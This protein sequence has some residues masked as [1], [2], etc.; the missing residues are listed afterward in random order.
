MFPIFLSIDISLPI[1]YYLNQ[2]V[3]EIQKVLTTI[4]MFVTLSI[5]MQIL[6]MYCFKGATTCLALTTL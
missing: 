4:I 6:L 1:I 3:H 5:L 2:F